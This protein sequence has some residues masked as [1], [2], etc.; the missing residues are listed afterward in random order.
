M[1]VSFPLAFLVADGGYP[2]LAAALLYAPPRSS[3]VDKERTCSCAAP[4]LA[5]PY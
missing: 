1:G 3:R 2:D 4:S 5:L